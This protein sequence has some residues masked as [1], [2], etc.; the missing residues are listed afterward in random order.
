[1]D[2]TLGYLRESLSNHLENEVCQRICKKMLE[3]RYVNEEE[4]VKDLDDNEM[5]FLNHVLEKEIKYAQ[6]EQD[7]KRA[8]ELNE[9]YELLL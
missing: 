2:V 9:V 4:F 7:Q 6:N 1:M 3:K 5:S 8:K